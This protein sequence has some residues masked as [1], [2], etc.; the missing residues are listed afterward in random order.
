MPKKLSSIIFVFSLSLTLLSCAKVPDVPVCISL[1][2]ERGFCTYT[3][4]DKEFYV[5]NE[6]HLF[7]G[8]TWEQVKISSLI[9]PASSWAKIKAY[10]LSQ[11]KKHKDCKDD[12]SKWEA[13]SSKLEKPKKGIINE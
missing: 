6:D 11:C 1:D 2:D 4:S 3:I 5:D 8:K 9:M 13:K 7:E 10:I 12:I